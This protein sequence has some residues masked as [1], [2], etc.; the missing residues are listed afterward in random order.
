VAK[1]DGKELAVQLKFKLDNKCS[2]IQA[3][4]LAI[5]KAIE[6]IVTIEITENTPRTATIFTDSRISTDSTTT[7]TSSKKP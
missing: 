4:Q 7:A 1:F 6:V 3:E 2:N 5:L